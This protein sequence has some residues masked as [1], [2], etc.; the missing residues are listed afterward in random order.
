[1][2]AR[3]KSC[4]FSYLECTGDDRIECLKHSW[5]KVFTD[6]GAHVIVVVESVLPT[7]SPP[8]VLESRELRVAIARDVFEP[9]LVNN[10]G[11]F[12]FA[13]LKGSRLVDSHLQGH[14]DAC[15]LLAN[16]SFVARP[17]HAS[18]SREGTVVSRFVATIAQPSGLT[19]GIFQVSRD[20]HL[21]HPAGVANGAFRNRDHNP[22]LTAILCSNATRRMLVAFHCFDK[23]RHWTNAG[24]A[25]FHLSVWKV[26]TAG[27]RKFVHTA[28][29]NFCPGC[30]IQRPY[31]VPAI[32]QHGIQQHWHVR[33]GLTCL[34]NHA[35]NQ[36]MT[37]GHSC[38]H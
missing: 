20:W 3:Q 12:G 38:R 37:R 5:G 4:N 11:N 30:P 36:G 28:R 14:I 18:T 10:A 23:H 1:M 16:D 29:C 24:W 22:R 9:G 15:L 35:A 7:G 21:G 33:F 6:V 8:R 19:I 13:R 26:C 34:V 27:C 25:T 2:P 32:L 17:T 31:R